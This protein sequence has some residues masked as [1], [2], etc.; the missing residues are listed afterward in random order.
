MCAG[1]RH[2]EVKA[3]MLEVKLHM[4]VHSAATEAVEGSRVV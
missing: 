4:L 1:V 3:N 2:R